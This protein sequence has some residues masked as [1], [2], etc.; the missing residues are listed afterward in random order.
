[1][2]NSLVFDE[3]WI[4][5]CRILSFSHVPIREVQYTYVWSRYV[6]MWKLQFCNAVQ[7]TKNH[8]NE[9]KWIF[10]FIPNNEQIA[11]T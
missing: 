11:Y 5:I 2:H 1:M 3:W 6:Y 9:L 7:F 10:I 8:S 4:I